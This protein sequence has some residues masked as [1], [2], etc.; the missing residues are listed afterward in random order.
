VVELESS[1][2]RA[3]DVAEVRRRRQAALNI[4][5][6]DPAAFSAALLG[7]PLRSYQV[8]PARA[9]VRA[10]M[11]GPRDVVT[12][13][14][15]RQA[16]KN[17]LSAHVEAYLMVM[18]SR[19][20]GGIV[21]AAP[22]YKP[23][24]ITSLQRLR[25]AL[26]TPRLEPSHSRWGYVVGLGLATTTFLSAEPSA[27]VVGATASI[28]LEFD[29]AQDISR[30]KH[31]REFRP[32]AASTNA[33][34]IYYGTAWSDDDLLQQ[35]KQRAL[36][37]E[38]ADGIRRHFE[39]PWEAVA[40]VNPAYGAYVRGEIARLGEEHVIVK[41]QYRL[42]PVSALDALLTAGQLAALRGDH[43]RQ[44][45]PDA[46]STYVCGID[47]AGASEEE[48]DA[49]GRASERDSTAISIGAVSLHDLLPAVRLVHHRLWSGESFAEKYQNLG[50][51]VETWR[52]R[53]VVVDATGIGA[54]TAEYLERRFGPER[55]ERFTFT[56]A[57]KSQLG[58]DVVAWINTG[59]L[60]QYRE[61][62]SD[63]TWRLFFEQ[64][65]QLRR[66]VKPSKQIAWGSPSGH[67]D[68]FVS[69]A[70]CARAALTA[71]P[72]GATAM[73]EPPLYG[74]GDRDA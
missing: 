36:E 45:E 62:P 44:E 61:E 9:I 66:T 48:P 19:R 51:L 57:S 31:D 74:A 10:A 33:P 49:L 70:L 26:S 67:D 71:R 30:E 38:R 18:H 34:S 37:L 46:G 12:V 58:Y 50:D 13:M 60:K 43:D 29:E 53:K 11:R 27:N 25:S 35:A 15:S 63:P 22:T 28:C 56:G 73:I 55:V 3:A 14:M 7:R 39:Y 54:S 52:C 20:G 69:A 40:E 2:E 65:R 8:E 64:A 6:S 68:L 59:R 1:T 21:K 5:L 32:M 41:T 42:L 4:A 23:Q 47:I 24:L 17:E 16:G 72:A